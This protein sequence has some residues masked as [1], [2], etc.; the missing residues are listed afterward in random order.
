M[1]RIIRPNRVP[2]KNARHFLEMLGQSQKNLVALMYAVVWETTEHEGLTEKVIE[3][4]ISLLE[5]EAVP[6]FEEAMELILAQIEAQLT[7]LK[8]MEDESAK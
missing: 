4:A 3:T 2:T 6:T 7:Q 5:P 1:S 8:E